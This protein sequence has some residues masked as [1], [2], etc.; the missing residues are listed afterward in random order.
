MNKE[1]FIEEAKKLGIDLI[2]QYVGY[3]S[4]YKINYKNVEKRITVNWWDIKNNPSYKETFKL[5]YEVNDNGKMGEI[6][7]D[8]FKTIFPGFTLYIK[9]SGFIYVKTPNEL[10]EK[11]EQIIELEEFLKNITIKEK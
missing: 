1:I 2:Q 7:N 9:N 4:L 10:L 6:L 3:S 11:I 8:K 5:D